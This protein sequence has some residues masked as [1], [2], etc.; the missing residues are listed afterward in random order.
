MGKIT[1]RVKEENGYT[2]YG[3]WECGEFSFTARK[4]KTYTEM[5]GKELFTRTG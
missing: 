4:F 3:E 1:N 2:C 5:L